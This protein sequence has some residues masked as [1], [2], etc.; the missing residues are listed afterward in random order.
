MRT[1]LDDSSSLARGPF[2][3]IHRSIIR[4]GAGAAS[5][6]VAKRWGTIRGIEPALRKD[7]RMNTK[8]DAKDEALV[9]ALA[10][11]YGDEARARALMRR[12]GASP[13][14]LPSFD[15]PIEFW[16]RI[17]EDAHL[18]RLEG[19]ARAIARAAA[20]EHPH[21]E[22][23]SAYVASRVESR[24]YPRVPPSLPEGLEA[25]EPTQP[26]PR[27]RAHHD[28]VGHDDHLWDTGAAASLGVLAPRIPTTTR[29]P[30]IIMGGRVRHKRAPIPRCPDC[31]GSLEPAIISVRFELAPEAAA[32]RE[33]PGY[34]CA[35]GSEWPEPSAMRL[36]H[37]AAFGTVRMPGHR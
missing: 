20:E 16:L 35:C 17:V 31:N 19:G 36:A 10:E 18:G 15:A 28:D 22:V 24:T 12:S 4:C 5:S 1:I 29:G 23:F 33:V 25:R 6:Y 30:T 32:T 27:T 7:R 37:A 2:E 21:H 3:S 13:E 11:T 14:H 9:R 34:R 26:W 8:L